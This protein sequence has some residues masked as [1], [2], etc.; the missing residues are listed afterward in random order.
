MV[1][2]ESSRKTVV[3]TAMPWK[4]AARTAVTQR[5]EMTA[6]LE[7]Q[8][9]SEYW[10]GNTEAGGKTK[11]AKQNKGQNRPGAGR[12]RR[13]PGVGLRTGRIRVRPD[14]V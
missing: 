12:D 7:A 14:S 9:Q 11:M 2:T 1:T 8:R 5:Q 3:A 13:R 4:P 6:D 10:P